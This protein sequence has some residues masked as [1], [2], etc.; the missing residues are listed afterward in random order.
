MSI[1]VVV[2]RNN[3]HLTKKAVNSLQSCVD[4]VLVV[5]NHSSDGTAEWLRA[6][7][8]LAMY[9]QV[10]KS[11]AW[12]WN[13]ALKHIWKAG[14]TEALVCN[15]DIEVRLDTYSMLVSTPYEFVSCVSVDSK[16]QVGVAGDKST[17]YLIRSAR[18]HPDFSCFLIRK[19]VTDAIGFFNESYYP[20][21]CEDCDYH[22]RMHRAGIKAM[23]VDLPFLHHGAQTVKQASIGEQIRIRRGAE[24]NRERF[25]VKYGCLPGTPE[26]SKLFEV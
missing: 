9:P 20:A 22:V 16:S 2:A 4:N 1:A 25:R 12:C 17:E 19:T 6:K 10:V 24:E 7:R 26:Y 23:C 21:Y 15:N 11:L 3:L 14:Y 5:D 8:T 18:P 13:T